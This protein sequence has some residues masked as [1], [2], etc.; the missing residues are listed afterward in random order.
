[1]QSRWNHTLLGEKQEL[2]SYH[3]LECLDFSLIKKEIR[4]KQDKKKVPNDRLVN[5]LTK[6][7]CSI[8][9]LNDYLDEVKGDEY[10]DLESIALEKSML[11][12]FYDEC[13][14]VACS[15]SL[16]KKSKVRPLKVTS[17]LHK[18]LP[19]WMWKQLRPVKIHATMKE[20]VMNF[21]SRHKL[22]FIFPV[23][24]LDTF[25]PKLSS[26]PQES[27]AQVLTALEEDGEL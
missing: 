19:N 17:L 12:E 24:S 20:Q 18:W 14:A 5:T 22:P 21:C 23:V 27:A 8:L 4:K 11:G 25:I 7:N 1:M 9:A 3:V 26:T 13:M 16:S 2:F 6:T 10:D 15:S